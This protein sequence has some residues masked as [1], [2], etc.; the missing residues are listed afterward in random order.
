MDRTRKKENK[1]KGE[2]GDGEKR[3][4]QRKMRKGRWGKK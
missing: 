2:K 1:R 3:A 4:T